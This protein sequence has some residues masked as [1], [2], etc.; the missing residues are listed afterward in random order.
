VAP[1]S[2]GL[3]ATV[4]VSDRDTPRLTEATPQIERPTAKTFFPR[5]RDPGRFHSPVSAAIDQDSLIFVCCIDFRPAVA[6]F[7]Y[8][9]RFDR[10]AGF[11]KVSDDPAAC[12]A[13]Q[14]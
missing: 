2:A 13:K 3:Q 12:A 1:N 8:P 6:R 7:Q 4:R 5:L 11:A 9:I 14:R 10:I